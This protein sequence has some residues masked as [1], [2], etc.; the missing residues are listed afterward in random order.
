MHSF[1]RHLSS[2]FQVLGVQ[3]WNIV[4]EDKPRWGGDGHPGRWKAWLPESPRV[5]RAAGSAAPVIP[6]QMALSCSGAASSGHC[7]P[8]STVADRQGV[9]LTLASA[10]FYLGE[11]GKQTNNC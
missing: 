3:Q 1:K 10:F 2:M 5:P 4:D 6:L 8:V 9:T 11:K 7:R